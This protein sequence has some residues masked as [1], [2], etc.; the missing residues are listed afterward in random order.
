[1][2]SEFNSVAVSQIAVHASIG[3]GVW[4]ALLGGLA[5]TLGRW[6]LADA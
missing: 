3:I 1:V 5:G 6:M 4:V 2:E